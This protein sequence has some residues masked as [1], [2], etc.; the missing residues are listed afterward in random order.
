M[1]SSFSERLKALRAEKG[2]R[3]EDAAEIFGVSRA[4]LSA[5]EM[6]KSVPDLNVLN[7]MADFYEVSADYL[8]G[9]T[10]VK[11]LYKRQRIHQ[12]SSCRSMMLTKSPNFPTAKQLGCR[13]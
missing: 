3:S 11:K 13:C 7:K 6:G 4:T 9:R 10:D 12:P 8:C 1:I 2:L 5:Y